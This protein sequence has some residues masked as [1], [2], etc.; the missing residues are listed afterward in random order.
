MS[1]LKQLYYGAILRRSFVGERHENIYKTG[2][3]LLPFFL[4]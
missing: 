3:D 1:A 4:R 2:S